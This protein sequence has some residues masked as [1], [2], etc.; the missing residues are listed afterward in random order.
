MSTSWECMTQWLCQNFQTH[1]QFFILR[2]VLLNS[3]SIHSTNTTLTRRRYK[4]QVNL[5]CSFCCLQGWCM[6]SPFS[7]GELTT[8]V[9][10]SV[11][12]SLHKLFLVFFPLNFFMI[13]WPWGSSFSQAIWRTF[14]TTYISLASLAFTRQVTCWHKYKHQETYMHTCTHMHKHRVERE[15]E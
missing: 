9:L 2:C 1:L 4:R 6:S 7:E 15:K 8:F 3:F 13:V 11:N 12:Y 14:S 10:L 5:P